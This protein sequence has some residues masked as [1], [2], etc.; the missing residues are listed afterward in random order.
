MSISHTEVI[1]FL[2]EGFLEI[3]RIVESS[4][5][6]TG[7]TSELS[8]ELFRNAIKKK[9]R[10]VIKLSSF[11]FSFPGLEALQAICRLL[12]EKQT[13]RVSVVQSYKDHWRRLSS[14]SVSQTQ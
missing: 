14:T 5:F 7:C 12:T 9:K 13:P 6:Q 2:L 1:I 8:K 4:P 3:W 10:N 11:H